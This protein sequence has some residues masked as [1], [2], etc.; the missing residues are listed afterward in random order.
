MDDDDELVSW[1]DGGTTYSVKK[2]VVKKAAEENDMRSLLYNPMAVYGK[3]GTN[4]EDTSDN[5]AD[6]QPED[7]SSHY[8]NPYSTIPSQNVWTGT[9]WSTKL[10]EIKPDP[11]YDIEQLLMMAQ[12]SQVP[13]LEKAV[14]ELAEVIKRLIEKNRLGPIAALALI[15]MIENNTF[16]ALIDT[17]NEVYKPGD[18]EEDE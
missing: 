5:T 1:S 18:E 2:S 13:S 3:M 11:N 17:I 9:D 10:P 14:N 6:T 8:S 16:A 4:E 12:L 7:N 15:R